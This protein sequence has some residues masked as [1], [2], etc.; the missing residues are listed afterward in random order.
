M[1]EEEGVEEVK[2]EERQWEEITPR[3]FDSVKVSY[4]VCLNTMG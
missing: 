3:P 1:K 4:V 2:F